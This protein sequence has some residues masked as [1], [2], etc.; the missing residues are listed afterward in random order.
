M[1]RRTISATVGIEQRENGSPLIVGH[2]AVF[3][4]SSEP[5][6][7]YKIWDDYVERVSPTA[8]DR[9][10]R[11][12]DDARALFNHDSSL[13]LGRVS[14]GTLRLSVDKRGL[15]YE[16]DPPDTQVGR[17][18]VTSIKRG[19]VDGS[20][21]AFTVKEVRMVDEDGV[22]LRIL[23]DVELFDVGPV[24]YPAY[25]ATSSTVRSL[26]SEDTRA[27]RDLAEHRKRQEQALR[28]K[29][30]LMEIEKNGD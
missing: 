18:V 23:E 11:E 5:G 19:D 2:A 30:R 21:F 1:E 26:I 13:V 20:S 24:T 25:A 7:Q 16:I 3:Y 6:T 14:A 27:W 15:R 28:V 22:T 29:L 4:R 10:I 9:A 12:K 17:D 8:F